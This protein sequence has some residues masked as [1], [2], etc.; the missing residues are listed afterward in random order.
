[1]IKNDKDLDAPTE[2]QYAFA[3]VIAEELDIPLPE[4][5]SKGAYSNFI[6]SNL[7]KFKRSKQKYRE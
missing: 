7:N 3:K 1:M 6:H 4:K 2:R 5:F